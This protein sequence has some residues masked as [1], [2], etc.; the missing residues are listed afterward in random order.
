VD[1]LQKKMLRT[2]ACISSLVDNLFLAAAQFNQGGCI[3]AGQL[4]WL[5]R[6][7]N[8]SFSSL[9]VQTRYL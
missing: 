7:F 5:Q 2:L 8:L 1:K 9:Q 6:I 3:P 4:L